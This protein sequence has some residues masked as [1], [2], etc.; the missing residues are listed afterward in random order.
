LEGTN[1]EAA[2][3]YLGGGKTF[4]VPIDGIGDDDIL[5]GCRLSDIAMG[6]DMMGDWRVQ[7][8]DFT[9]RA[10]AALKFGTTWLMRKPGY[11]V[12]ND[13]LIAVEITTPRTNA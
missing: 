3:I 13:R 1:Y 7:E 10:L 8:K 6:Y 2:P 12:V 4:L 5:I 9:L 11:L